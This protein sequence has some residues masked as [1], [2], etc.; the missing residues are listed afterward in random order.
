MMKTDGSMERLCFA[1]YNKDKPDDMKLCIGAYSEGIDEPAYYSSYMPIEIV[2]IQFPLYGEPFMLVYNE[3]PTGTN[4]G[5]Y[6][7]GGLSLASTAAA[8]NSLMDLAKTL[9]NSRFPEEQGVLD[10]MLIA[11]SSAESNSEGLPSNPG[12]PQTEE[13]DSSPDRD[14]V[15][16]AIIGGMFGGKL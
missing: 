5:Q 6:C 12:G 2:K 9:Y 8:I 14:M 1:E 16:R 10:L 4:V 13:S 11:K 7:V 15:L 3:D